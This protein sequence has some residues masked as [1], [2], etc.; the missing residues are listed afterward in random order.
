MMH[1]N[2]LI[3]SLKKKN[4]KEAVSRNLGNDRLCQ[5]MHKQ[6][7]EETPEWLPS[8]QMSFIT[9]ATFDRC[10]QFSKSKLGTWRQVTGFHKEMSANTQ[11]KYTECKI[12]LQTNVSY[13]YITCFLCRKGLRVTERGMPS[14]YWCASLKDG[15]SAYWC[16]YPLYLKINGR[17]LN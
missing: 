1:R 13:L 2:V 4:E 5:S 11:N 7:W 6:K 3:L 10:S 16:K 17:K 15:N 12:F 14:S 9:W 8:A